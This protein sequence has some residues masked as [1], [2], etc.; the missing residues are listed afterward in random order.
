LG[1]ALPI[2]KTKT[3]HNRTQQ[4]SLLL[5]AVPEAAVTEN[6]AATEAAFMQTNRRRTL[7]RTDP[8]RQRMQENER[9]GRNCLSLTEM[10]NF[11]HMFV[12][13]GTD[14]RFQLRIIE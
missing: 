6:V 14:A 10:S 12:Q 8:Q 13:F 7:T 2:S 4:C 3:V 1:S 9:G 5:T 11:E